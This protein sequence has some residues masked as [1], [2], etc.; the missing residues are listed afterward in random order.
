MTPEAL[1]I[2]APMVIV[3]TAF[4]NG[5]GIVA[6]KFGIAPKHA[7]LSGVIV[8]GV[9]YTAFDQFLPAEL[10]QSAISFALD[11]MAVA[12]LIYEYLIKTTAKK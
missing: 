5:L 8:L 9:A 3:A 4:V 2:A 12:V 10:K 1:L 11:S 6:K 7:L